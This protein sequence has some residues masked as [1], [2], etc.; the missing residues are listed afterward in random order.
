MAWTPPSSPR[1]DPPATA[2]EDEARLGVPDSNRDATDPADSK[3]LFSPGSRSADTNG[4][5]ATGSTEPAGAATRS[6]VE[7]VRAREDA[8]DVAR[9]RTEEDGG[10]LDVFGTP[11]AGSQTA[12]DLSWHCV[13]QSPADERVE[14]VS[15]PLE[16]VPAVHLP[17]PEPED[18]T[19]RSYSQLANSTRNSHSAEVEFRSADVRPR[20]ETRQAGSD[21]FGDEQAVLA[22]SQATGPTEQDGLTDSQEDVLLAQSV[23]RSQSD[24][25]HWLHE[26]LRLAKGDGTS[27]IESDDA[28]SSILEV[29]RHV[30]LGGGESQLTECATMLEFG[31]AHSIPDEEITISTIPSVPSPPSGSSVADAEFVSALTAEPRAHEDGKERTERDQDSHRITDLEKRRVWPW[32]LL[33][34]GLAVVLAYQRW[35]HANSL[36]AKAAPAPPP[37]RSFAYAPLNYSVE[38]STFPTPL[39]VGPRVSSVWYSGVFT[40]VVASAAAVPSLL[41]GCSSL[42][43]RRQEKESSP[44]TVAFELAEARSRLSTAIKLYSQGRL[45]EAV[46]TLSAILE[47]ACPSPD[48]AIA[49]EWLG[50]AWYRLGRRGAH[51]AEDDLLRSVAAFERSIRLDPGRAS[52][53]ASLGR[54]LFRLGRNMEAAMAL[55]AA[56]KRD[57]NLAFAHE[58]LA[59]ALSRVEPVSHELV[60][61][62]LCR[63]VELDPD[64]YTAHAFLG[65]HL[66][67]RG[68]VVPGR[69]D[70]AKA[71]LL[72][73]VALRSDYPAAHIRL[74]FIA[75]EQLDSAAAARHYAAA[76]SARRTGF[77]DSAVMPAS[78]A[79]LDGPSPYLAWSFQLPAHSPRRLAVLRQASLE[80]PYD[81]VVGHLLAVE[82]APKR[83]LN[84]GGN[85]SPCTTMDDR[86]VARETVLARRVGRYSPSD[87][88]VAHGLYALVLLALGK[89]DAEPAYQRFWTAVVERRRRAVKTPSS[90]EQGTAAQVA[91]DDEVDR[92][93]AYL[94]MAFFER[95]GM[96]VPLRAVTVPK[97]R[98]SPPPRPSTDRPSS[99]LPTRHSPSKVSSP[100]SK[101]RNPPPP[102]T[103]TPTITPRR[104]SNRLAQ[105][106]TP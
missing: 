44:R 98:S 100:S 33:S 30:R 71:A 17:T 88:I 31:G 62:H 66:H 83:A 10:G 20:A 93:V 64:L 9:S 24:F 47:L 95:R 85:G 101:K 52:P 60:E 37:T 55:R 76:V 40:I 106:S 84:R 56:I 22:G 70:A 67:L 79:A 26:T 103:P 80:H 32:Q 54:T 35:E 94:A 1:R 5:G 42:Y 27:T 43:P 65:E 4:T 61:R 2:R 97:T 75:N 41:R 72:R 89:D 59:K 28:L 77:R 86:L 58:W 78:E 69:T 50:R 87:D 53:R 92:A 104:R 16:T 48:K 18:R 81:E 25:S 13:D 63:A 57:D 73:A 14:D 11:L 6:L 38:V 51:S 45:H 36:L 46:Q 105:V 68:G 74:A 99:A 39:A 34:L 90:G 29:T 19:R 8:A 3:A 15:V 82:S 23:T 12:S 96:P 7:S 102:S 21:G 49:S 91:D